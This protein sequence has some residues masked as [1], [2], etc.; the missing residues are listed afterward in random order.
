M[1]VALAPYY[2]IL[3]TLIIVMLVVSFYRNHMLT[4]VL[5]FTGTAMALISLTNLCNC[6]PWWAQDMLITDHTSTLLIGVSLLTVLV[7]IVTGFHY[8]HQI[9]D[10]KEEYYLLLLSSLLGAMIMI[11]SRNFVTFFLGLELMSVP[12]YALV[13]YKRT[14][15]ESVEAGIKYLLLAGASTATLV[16]GLALMYGASGTMDLYTFAMYLSQL[17]QM[18]SFVLA[19]LGLFLASVGFKLALVPFHVWTP[20]VYQGSPAPI[21]AFLTSVGKIGTFVF[22]LRMLQEANLTSHSPVFYILA[23]LSVTSMIVGNLLALSQTHVKR[24]LAFSSIAHMGYL[25]IALLAGGNNGYQAGMFYLII[26]AISSIGAFSSIALLTQHQKEPNDIS[27]Y[28]SLYQRSPFLAIVFSASIFSLAGMPLTAGFIAKI[29][30][31][32]AGASAALW[33]LVLLLVVNSGIGL[34][35][36]TRIVSAVFKPAETSEKIRLPLVSSL[37]LAFIIVIIVWLGVAPGGFLYWLVP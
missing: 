16:F 14:Q 5:S 25:I 1:F 13:A 6:L 26:Y 24:I 9:E 17:S 12:L 32:L 22:L 31:A 36:Y 34:Y 8:I 35:Y 23:F 29:Y 19:G 18:P 10:K 7:L 28:Q 2:I 30:L 11:A 27:E 15:R 3:V 37:A 4:A 33:L 20:D 21:T